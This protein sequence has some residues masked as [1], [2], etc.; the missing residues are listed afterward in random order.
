LK[1]KKKEHLGLPVAEGTLL[2][3]FSK[4]IFQNNQQGFSLSWIIHVEKFPIYSIL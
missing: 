2:L 4:E 3:K 1:T